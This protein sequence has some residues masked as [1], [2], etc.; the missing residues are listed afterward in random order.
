MTPI[1]IRRE[2]KQSIKIGSATVVRQLVRFNEQLTPHNDVPAGKLTI[3][4]RSGSLLESSSKAN[5]R[6]RR[7]T[8]PTPG[9]QDCT[10]KPRSHKG[11]RVV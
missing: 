9:L 8:K 10:V 11:R 3:L 4:R 7:G 5:D 2:L 6:V 1:P